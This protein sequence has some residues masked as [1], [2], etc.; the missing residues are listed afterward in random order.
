MKSGTPTI[1]SMGPKDR[2][3]SGR[4]RTRGEI[5][6]TEQTTAPCQQ[7]VDNP[8][9]NPVTRVSSS[10]ESTVHWNGSES[11]GSRR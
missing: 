8:V 5:H 9:E 7:S 3:M 4:C 10:V 6:D 2:L 1:G 11:T